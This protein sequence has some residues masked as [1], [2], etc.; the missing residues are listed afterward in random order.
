MISKI[1]IKPTHPS[2]VSATMARGSSKFSSMITCLPLPS[3]FAVSIMLVP[4]SV[5]NSRLFK[6]S[7]VSPS[8]SLSVKQH[9]ILSELIS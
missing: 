8:G 4:V 1:E 3:K 2:S 7:K 5:Q 6:V 9:N